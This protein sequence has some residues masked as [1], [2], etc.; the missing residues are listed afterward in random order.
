MPKGIKSQCYDTDQPTAALIEDLEERGLLEE[1]LVIWGGEFG[2]TVYSQGTLTAD[3][4]GRDDSHASRRRRCLSVAAASASTR[5][6]GR[7]YP[8]TTTLTVRGARA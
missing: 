1:T 3:A 7:S 8:D 5:A 2:R 6:T 4:Y